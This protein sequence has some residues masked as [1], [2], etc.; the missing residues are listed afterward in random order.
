MTRIGG[1][2]VQTGDRPAVRFVDSTTVS[3]VV[4]DQGGAD[5]AQVTF[6]ATA[7]Y[8]AGADKVAAAD[9][10]FPAPPGDGTLAVVFNT[11]DSAVRLGA[12]ANGAWVHVLLT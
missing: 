4:A 6:T 10:D 3:A 11:T 7:V 5:E 8:L 12:R 1:A 9:V 2:N